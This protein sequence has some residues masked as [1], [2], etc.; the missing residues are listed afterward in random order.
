MKSS[1]LIKACKWFVVQWLKA[2]TTAATWFHSCWSSARL[3]LGTIFLS[4]SEDF[5]PWAWS[6][7]S[8][9]GLW[10][11]N[12]LSQKLDPLPEGNRRASERILV[13][14]YTTTLLDEIQASFDGFVLLSFVI[15]CCTCCIIIEELQKNRNY[16][17]EKLSTELECSDQVFWP[18]F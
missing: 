11:D 13:F 3:V 12:W 14:Y 10:P 15:S 6:L 1:H 17:T 8:E 2:V 18:R 5:L 4:Y 7:E 9:A 16:H